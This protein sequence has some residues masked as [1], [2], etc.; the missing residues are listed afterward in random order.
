MKVGTYT[1]VVVSGGCPSGVHDNAS[2]CNL[3]TSGTGHSRG[4]SNWVAQVYNF[5][6]AATNAEVVSAYN[7][8]Q[9]WLTATG[10]NVSVGSVSNMQANMSV[11]YQLLLN[12][13]SAAYGKNYTD[14]VQRTEAGSYSE[15]CRSDASFK[16]ETEDCKKAIDDLITAHA[17]MKTAISGHNFASGAFSNNTGTNGKTYV[18]CITGSTAG[19]DGV[20]SAEAEIG[21][22]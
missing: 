18:Q 20:K 19:S 22:Y 11:L 2:A 15:I 12:L 21:T 16:Q 6:P 7:R 17:A 14:P 1:C 4:G 5:N 9:Q 8:T 13:T 10:A 3:A